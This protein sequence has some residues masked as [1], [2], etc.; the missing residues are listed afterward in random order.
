MNASNP[1]KY[2]RAASRGVAIDPDG[3]AREVTLG[4]ESIRLAV[5]GSF[6]MCQPRKDM[7]VPL[8]AWVNVKA[9]HY[10]MPN[11][12]ATHLLHQL[13]FDINIVYGPVV[14][15]PCEYDVP[16]DDDVGPMPPGL[17][18]GPG[19]TPEAVNIL[20]Q[21]V[22]TC[23]VKDATPQRLSG[24]CEAALLQLYVTDRLFR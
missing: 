11:W 8:D 19:F 5:G 23:N 2:Y 18:Y 3:R 13:R 9:T 24:S 14:L 7:R 21:G 20:F 17:W 15:A 6:E 16:D 1:S 10:L 12:P 22:R 4:L